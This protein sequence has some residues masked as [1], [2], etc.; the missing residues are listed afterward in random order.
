M[1][2]GVDRLDYVKGIPQKLQGLMYFFNKYPEW[3][4]KVRFVLSLPP[5]LPRLII[6]LVP[7]QQVV[8]VQVALPARIKLRR[9]KKLKK[10]VRFPLSL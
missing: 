5:P 2:L 1:L 6:Q 7:P 10:E 9:H 3:R 4:G 8:L